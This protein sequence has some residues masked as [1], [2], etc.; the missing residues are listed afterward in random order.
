M[1]F[2]Q[3]KIRTQ[4]IL[5]F[6]IE[7]SLLYLRATCKNKQKEDGKKKKKAT[8]NGTMLSA[9]WDNLSLDSWLTRPLSYRSCVARL[10]L[11]VEIIHK[12]W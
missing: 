6:A 12:L 10:D 1:F 3:P 2:S 8:K 11:S 7:L 4:R 9:S 5:L